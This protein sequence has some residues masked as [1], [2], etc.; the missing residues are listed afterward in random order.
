[1]IKFHKIA[2]PPKK[3]PKGEEHIWFASY[4]AIYVSDNNGLPRLITAG[5]QRG[6]SIPTGKPQEPGIIYYCNSNGKTYISS[7]DKWLELP[8]KGIPG[9]GGGAGTASTITVEDHGKWFTSIN[10]EGA[11]AEIAEAMPH[12]FGNK[13]LENYGGN[14]AQLKDSKEA[15]ITPTATEKGD[16]GSGWRI[17]RKNDKGTSFGLQV[18]D[19][20]KLYAGISPQLKEI[21]SK[22]DLDSLGESLANKTAKLKMTVKDGLKTNGKTIPGGQDIEIDFDKVAKKSHSHNDYVKKDGDEMTDSLVVRNKKSGKDSQ[23]SVQSGASNRKTTFYYNTRTDNSGL[24]DL[25]DGLGIL[26][27]SNGLGGLSLF[28]HKK[29]QSNPESGKMR[30]HA[31]RDVEVMASQTERNHNGAFRVMAGPSTRSLRLVNEYGGITIGSNSKH[32]FIDSTSFHPDTPKNLLISG[33]HYRQI[34]ELRVNAKFAYFEGDHIVSKKALTIGQDLDTNSGSGDFSSKIYMFPYELSGPGGKNTFAEMGF[35]QR[36]QTLTLR[37]YS[38]QVR[39]MGQGDNT[40]RVGDQIVVTRP[41]DYNGKTISVGGEYSVIELVGNK[42]IIGR[43][44]GQNISIHISNIKLANPRKVTDMTSQMNPLTVKATKFVNTSSIKYKN[45][46]GEMEDGA[47][48]RVM[49]AKVY[50]YT[51]KNDMAAKESVGL[52]IE[53]GAPRE[54]IDSEGDS[55]DNYAM[56]SFLWKAVQELTEEVNRLKDKLGE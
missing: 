15:Y 27:Y 40:I 24:Y 45:V 53:K 51:F 29:V 30:L 19:N 48:D 25:S 50:E 43:H 42:A 12:Y 44:D 26:R 2:S 10:V 8:L 13:T 18:S 9:S 36:H 5:N 3:V 17:T 4:G 28:A 22:K 56:T 14:V 52:I 31:D 37:S 47:L 33:G 49:A 54:V 16:A 39:S 46:I 41:I 55:I 21:A 1:M 34:E 20:G 38:H 35:S 6:D 7:P 23:V 32:G 11:L